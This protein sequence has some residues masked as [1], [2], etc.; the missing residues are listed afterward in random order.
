MIGDPHNPTHY[1]DGKLSL[2]QPLR[3]SK[4]TTPFTTS[5]GEKKK[6][7]G[8]CRNSKE[9]GYNTSKEKIKGG[10]S[11][12]KLK[13]NANKDFYK[14]SMMCNKGKKGRSTAMVW[15]TIP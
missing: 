9:K 2:T 5:K 7:P 10:K 15:P 12:R 8:K 13:Y 11:S 3:D 6:E 14:T 4:R 1:I